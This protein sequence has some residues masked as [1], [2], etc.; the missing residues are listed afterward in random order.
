MNMLPDCPWCEE[1]LTVAVMLKERLRHELETKKPEPKTKIEYLIKIAQETQEEGIRHAALWLLQHL[2]DISPA[3]V[4]AGTT[5][6]A[7]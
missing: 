7:A 4:Y 1:K 6:Q 2:F 5:K 3:D